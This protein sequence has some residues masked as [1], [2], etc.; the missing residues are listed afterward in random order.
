MTMEQKILPT[1]HFNFS[2]QNTSLLK[3]QDSLLLVF[4]PGDKQASVFAKKDVW[5]F[6]FWRFAFFSLA[7]GDH[8]SRDDFS[9]RFSLA[10]RDYTSRDDFSRRIPSESP[11]AAIIVYSDDFHI[12]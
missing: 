8:T 6:A 5:R 11:L 7:H 4:K 9:R 1:F 2:E 10:H 3:I 12:S